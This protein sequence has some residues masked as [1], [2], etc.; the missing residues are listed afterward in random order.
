MDD[1]EHPND[2]PPLTI[3][4]IQGLVE[5]IQDAFGNDFSRAVFTNHLLVL[6]EDVPGYE[7]GDVPEALIESAWAL[8]SRPG[9]NS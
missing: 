4:Q 8:Y 5:S 3:V 9:V 7:T 2:F 1:T 6:F